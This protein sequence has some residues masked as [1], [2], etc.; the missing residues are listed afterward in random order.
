[1]K[2][3][4]YFAL[5]VL[6]IVIPF[7]TKAA[8]SSQEKARLKKI[9]SNINIS[10]D[11]EITGNDAFF[12]VKFSNLNP[13]LYFKN[14][15]GN[16]HQIYSL[17]NNELVLYNYAD[18]GSYNF[19]FYGVNSCSG[20]EIG[21]LYVTLPSYNPLYQLSVCDNAKE[22]KLCQKWVKHSLNR[23]EFEKKVNEYKNS[24]GI[25][26]DSEINKQIS[27]IDF[28]MSFIKMYG[29]YIVI[30]IVVIIFVVKFIRY[31]KDSFGF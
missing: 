20:E 22:Y 2:K 8:C 14:P 3:L 18:G 17:E 1:M 10:Y 16:I 4:K 23:I 27:V 7:N 9:V 28:A 26:D 6:L 5:F 13:E 21:N 29:L 15:S 12:S 31:K 11:Y 25:I 30:V 19:K 24:N